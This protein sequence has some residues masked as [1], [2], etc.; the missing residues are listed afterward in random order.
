MGYLGMYVQLSPITATNNFPHCGNCRELKGE[1]ARQ[2]NRGLTT[3]GVIQPG[4][5]VFVAEIPGYQQLDVFIYQRRAG[6]GEG[7]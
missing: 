2:I 5:R 1:G 7:G 6:M 4:D 3:A